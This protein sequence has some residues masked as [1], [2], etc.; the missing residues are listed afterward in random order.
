MF[1]EGT[2]S[3]PDDATLLPNPAWK[4]VELN[5]NFKTSLATTLSINESVFVL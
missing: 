2:A 4:L 3:K 5:A 1:D